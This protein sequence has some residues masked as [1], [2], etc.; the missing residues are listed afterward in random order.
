MAPMDDW[1]ERFYPGLTPEQHK[2]NNDWFRNIL[3]MLEDTGELLVPSLGK[4]FNKQGFEITKDFEN[5]Q[6]DLEEI[7]EL[8]LDNIR[9]R[10]GL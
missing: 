6:K 1:S 3:N 2:N 9:N 8:S 4:S 7:R 10:F 5:Y